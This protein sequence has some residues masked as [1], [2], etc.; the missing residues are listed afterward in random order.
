MKKKF[1]NV[2]M[3]VVTAAILTVSFAACGTT[4]ED[5]TASDTGSASATVYY[6]VDFDSNG[7][8]DVESQQVEEGGYATEPEDPTKDGYYFGAWYKESDL[9]NTY[10]FSTEAVTADI[11]LYASWVDASSAS[12]MTF[13][14]NDGTDTVYETIY[15]ESGSRG[16]TAPSTDPSRDGYYFVGWYADTTYETAFS[17]L[18]RYSGNVEFYAKWLYINTFE[19]EHTQLTGLTDDIELGLANSLGEKYGQGYSNNPAGT[20]L[21]CAEGESGVSA[22]N[23]YYISYLYYEDAY[24]E[25]KVTAS[26]DV[27]DAMFYI[28]LTAEYYNMTFTDDNFTITVNDE[29]ISYTKIAITDAITDMSSLYKRPFSNHYINDIS[30]K[31]GENTIRLTVTNSDAPGSTGTMSAVAPM[32]DCIYVYADDSATLEM[33]KYNTSIVGE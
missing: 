19:A 1:L 8:S 9:V 23:G 7:G 24:L 26:E 20:A 32:V 16:N 21:I 6:T 28:R 29:E 3:A 5:S 30:L 25:F 14:M 27:D 10:S 22:S 17:S 31:E 12:T 13:Y 15:Y 33:T 18:T 2:A 4:E 11:T